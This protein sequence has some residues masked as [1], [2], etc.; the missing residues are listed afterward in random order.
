MTPAEVRKLFPRA[1]KPVLE[2]TDGRC[3]Q[4]DCPLL[5]MTQG[6]CT[7]CMRKRE[8]EKARAEYVG[9]FLGVPTC[10]NCG[11]VWLHEEIRGAPVLVFVFCVTC[12]K[13]Q[14]RTDR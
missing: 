10:S 4:C 3:L 7:P 8:V 12:G 11:S 1:R 14:P 5:D 9:W 6:R 2:P 13:I